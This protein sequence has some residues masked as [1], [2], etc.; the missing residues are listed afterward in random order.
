M[1]A[2]VLREARTAAAGAG[3]GQGE[4]EAACLRFCVEDDGCGIKPERL[5]DV[6]RRF[7]QVE[8]PEGGTGYKGTG[9]GLAICKEIVERQG[10]R[11]WAESAP[12]RGASFYFTVPLRGEP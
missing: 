8:R 9:L 7:V 4:A 12:G 11:I 6:F 10:G 3:A 1:R 5:E 2:Q